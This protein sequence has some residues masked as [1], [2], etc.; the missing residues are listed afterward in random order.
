MSCRNQD[1]YRGEGGQAPGRRDWPRRGLLI[2]A[3]VLAGGAAARAGGSVPVVN[4]A[5]GPVRGLYADGLAEFFGIPY[6]AA[7]VGAL[8]WMPPQ[9]HA[10]WGG[11]LQATQFAPVCAQVTTLGVFAGPPSSN[12]DCLYLNV[13]TPNLSG[14]AKLPVFV[15]MHG[16]GNVDGEANDY[17]GSKLAAQGKAVVVT[18]NYR[19]GLLGWLANPA[20][21]AE[22][23]A[24]ANYGLMDQQA[25]L[26]WVQAN[27]A[28]FGGDPGNVTLGGQSAGSLD[29]SANVVSPLAAGLFH[30]AI[31]ESI[32]T[33]STP[34]AAAEQ[35]GDAFATAAGCGSG[36][37][38]K[39][40]ACLRK[41]PAS[42]I[43]NLQGTAAANGPY[44]EMLISDGTVIPAAGV[45]AS[46][47]SGNFNH[48][49]IMSGVVH[50]EFNFL[51]AI[52]EYFGHPRRPA[53]AAEYQA[54]TTTTFG[55]SGGA[56]VLAQFPV[57][58]YATP[59]IAWDTAGTDWMVCP[60]YQIN[61]VLSTQV[62]VY[63]YEF[64]DQSVPSYFP[65][66]PGY[67]PLAYHTGDIQFLFPLWH[68]G[69]LGI[70]H[71]LSAQEQRLS[72][73][74]VAAWT[75]F[76]WTGNPNGLGNAPWPRYVASAKQPAYYLSENVPELTLE[77]D[78]E[79]AQDHRCAFWAGMP[80]F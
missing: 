56:R 7:P 61:R 46:Y 31:F 48:M 33:D 15:W 79:F 59:Q 49:P 14:S 53:S 24:F 80:S 35:A 67:Q 45:F 77:T 9:P 22:G 57:Q 60:Q 40:A 68:G 30:H 18:F 47:R 8:R 51:I 37:A 19:L 38:A 28:S 63:A 12:E 78:A 1:Q 20:L 42:Q 50:D 2:A 70:A 11:V 43:M 64:N 26:K 13:Y 55:A 3:M 36:A 75:N 66:M 21:D 16:G 25:A 4:T 72:D 52:D 32:V 34:L 76:A 27:A 6:A 29:T 23:H 44:V 69:P 54:W 39:V 5:E 71:P 73:E 58:S 65:K 41:L 62:P 74:L 17:D 10:P